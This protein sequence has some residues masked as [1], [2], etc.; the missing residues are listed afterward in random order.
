M[1]F[2]TKATTAKKITTKPN[3]GRAVPRV[4]LG[5][6]KLKKSPTRAVTAKLNPIE[7][8]SLSITSKD[9]SIGNN[10]SVRQ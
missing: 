6:V 5:G 3:A 1:Y 9:S 4:N 7:K 10:V 2:L 8:V